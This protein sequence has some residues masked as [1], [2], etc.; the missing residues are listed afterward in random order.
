[1]KNIF[2]G[3]IV[4][5]AAL[6]S[7]RGDETTLQQIDQVI[8]MYVDSAGQDMLNPGIENSYQTLTMN[9]V[10]GITDNAP[11]AVSLIYDADSLRYLEYVK[12]ARRIP[13]DTTNPDAKMYESEIALIYTQKKNDSV[14]V[15]IND[16]LRLNYIS[17]PEIFTLQNAWYNDVLV[18]TKEYGQPNIIKVHK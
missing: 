8:K 17:K 6:L 12:G 9:D 2:F 3:I 18:F 10:N 13:V 15:T 5:S 7:C 14:T 11:V 4:F 16:R 1:M